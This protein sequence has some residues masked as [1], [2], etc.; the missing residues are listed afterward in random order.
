MCV[1]TIYLLYLKLF[2]SSST[3]T[4]AINVSMFTDDEDDVS[5]GSLEDAASY[6]R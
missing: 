4:N 5:D 6:I 3:I 2:V 1:A